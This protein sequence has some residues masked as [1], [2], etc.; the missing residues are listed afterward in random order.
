MI[1]EIP[2]INTSH[3]QKMKVLLGSKYQDYMDLKQSYQYGMAVMSTALQNTY[4]SPEDEKT[5][6]KKTAIIFELTGRL[7]ESYREKILETT[8]QIKKR[9]LGYGV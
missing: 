2:D 7:N 4:N 1:P 3:V 8:L 5:K 6:A 9:I